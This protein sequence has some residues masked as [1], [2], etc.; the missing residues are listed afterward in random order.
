MA[1]APVA[2]RTADALLTLA[3]ELA[4]MAA[5]AGAAGSMAA[6]SL[7]LARKVSVLVH[8]LEEI[9]DFAWRNGGEAPSSSSPAEKL[10]WSCISE[11]VIALKVVRRFLVLHRGRILG[12]NSV[13]VSFNR[14]ATCWLGGFCLCRLFVC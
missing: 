13:V 6:E 5:D 12:E 11:M 10:K 8:L 1:S 2:V 4:A 7:R 3:H 9:R 14:P